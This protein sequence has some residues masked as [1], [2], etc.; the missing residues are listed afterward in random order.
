M[1]TAEVIDQFFKCRA[2]KSYCGLY[3]NTHSYT[4]L[5]IN[6]SIQKQHQ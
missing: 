1:H 6:N 4:L 3:I 2:K 5:I